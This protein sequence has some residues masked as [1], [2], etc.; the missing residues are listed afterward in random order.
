M[1]SGYRVQVTV[2]SIF[3]FLRFTFRGLPLNSWHLARKS[4]LDEV[5]I[6]KLLLIATLPVGEHFSR[7]AAQCPVSTFWDW[8]L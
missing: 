5:Q 3:L 7:K 1:C 6:V 2:A 4:L 8:G